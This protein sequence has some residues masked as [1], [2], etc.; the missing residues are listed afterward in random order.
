[1]HRSRTAAALVAVA[2]LGAGTVAFAG[3]SADDR[4]RGHDDRGRGHDHRGHDD[5]GRGH[6]HRGRGHRHHANRHRGAARAKLINAQG[7]RVGRV[8]LHELRRRDGVRVR[9]RV[10][11][12]PPGFHGFHVHAVGVCERPTFTSA[13]GHYNPTGDTHRDHA[14]DLPTLLVNADGTGVLATVTDRF[15]VRELRAGDGSAIMVHELPDNYANIPDRY[16][17]PDQTTLDTGDAGS[18]IACGEVR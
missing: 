6:D 9:V 10:H 13:G 4:G 3:P 11:G 14:G 18:R 16:G 5:R 15:S 7:D 8:R 17:E 1:M 2:T 12:L